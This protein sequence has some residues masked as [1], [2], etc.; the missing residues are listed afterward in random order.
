MDLQMII[1]AVVA[2]TGV[3]LTESP[4]QWR[5]NQDHILGGHV[6]NTYICI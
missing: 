1:I 5:C 2:Q 3:N 6:N 4:F